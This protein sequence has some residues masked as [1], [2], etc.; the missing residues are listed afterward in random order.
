MKQY[1][2]TILI[3][4]ILVS[5]AA[6]P[7]LRAQ[8]F[9]LRYNF[10]SGGVLK[11]KKNDITSAHIAG[12]G[13]IEEN[14]DRKSEA[15]I[16]IIGEGTVGT[17]VSYLFTQDTLFIDEQKN[18]EL[19]FRMSDLF[20]IL[21]GKRIRVS[22]TPRG[23]VRSIQV[24]DSINVNASFPVSLSDTML[25]QQAAI[26]PTL[27]HKPVKIGETWTDSRSDTIAPRMTVEGMGSN[28]GF[29][30]RTMK[31]TY[32]IAGEEVMGKYRCIKLTWKSTTKTEGQ[33][34]YGDVEVFTEEDGNTSGTLYFAHKE[35]ILVSMEF[36][37]FNETTTA[38]ISGND[39]TVMPSSTTNEVKLFLIP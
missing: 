25:S 19:G 22:I 10:S 8:E 4:F 24:I 32:T 36:R 15:S 14:I 35:D 34:K 23:D 26:F 3:V 17:T 39:N 2:P 11:Y 16:K 13:G 20:N 5:I 33:M 29:T 30:L 7:A 28:T 38:M 18:E 1:R 27:P 31:T 12:P 9:N 21:T 37:T 6:P